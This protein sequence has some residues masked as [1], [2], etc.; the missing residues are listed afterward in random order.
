MSDITIVVDEVVTRTPAPA[1]VAGLMLG[2]SAAM[3][4]ELSALVCVDAARAG[5]D[6]LVVDAPQVDHVPGYFAAA[7]T[8]RI[9]ETPDADIT[10]GDASDA[11][12]TRKAVRTADSAHNF[13][14]RGHPR[15]RPV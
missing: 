10:D 2:S 6:V 5:I 13:T 4:R 15:G 8:L 7:D 14:S 9:V 1:A 3:W 12:A 11:G